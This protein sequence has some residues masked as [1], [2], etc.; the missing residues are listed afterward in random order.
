MV[1]ELQIWARLT[2]KNVLPLLGYTTD[3]GLFYLSL[4]TEWMSNGTI[5]QY[6]KAEREKPV[7]VLY[8]VCNECR[9]SHSRFDLK[10]LLG[11]GDSVR[12]WVPP[13]TEHSSLRYEVGTSL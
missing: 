11:K 2:H 7:D 10:L 5:M 12:A 13:H 9:A 8:M 3:G 4:I 1:R 6:M